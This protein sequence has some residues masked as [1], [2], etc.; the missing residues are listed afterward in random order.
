MPRNR[1][2]LY[3]N[4]K[5]AFL[6]FG[7]ISHRYNIRNK[8]LNKVFFLLFK[9][10]YYNKRLTWQKDRPDSL[11][12]SYSETLCSQAHILRSIVGKKYTF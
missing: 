5:P 12:L 6:K 3:L 1:E 11:D 2:V 10:V 4:C 9:F 7:P 8:I